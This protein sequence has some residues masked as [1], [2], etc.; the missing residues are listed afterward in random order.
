MYTTLFILALISYAVYALNKIKDLKDELFMANILSNQRK[1]RLISYSDEA[2]SLRARNAELAEA[3]STIADREEKLE[4]REN[5]FAKKLVQ[6][7][8]PSDYDDPPF[9]R[10]AAPRCPNPFPQDPHTWKVRDLPDMMTRQK[11]EL[12]IFRQQP[13]ACSFE[14][15]RAEKRISLAHEKIV[16]FCCQYPNSPTTAQLQGRY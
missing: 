7:Q 5:N 11:Q 2:D 15:M 1:E 3:L 9:I 10:V 14:V 12:N 13:D 4:E 6:G 16:S 8:R